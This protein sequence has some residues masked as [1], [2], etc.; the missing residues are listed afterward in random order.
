MGIEKWDLKFIELANYIATWSKDNS[1][2]V[3]S[4]IVDDS[5]RI[6]S[7]GYNGM[8]IG[9]DD[10]VKS[11]YEKPQKYFYFEHSERNAIYSCAYAGK[12][13]KNTTI[14]VQYYPCADCAR[15]IIQSGIKRVVCTKPDFNNEKWGES[16]RIA[17]ELFNECGIEVKYI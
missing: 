8:P 5:N 17:D 7:T 11:R 14:Y 3:G 15:A 12:S 2:K 4:V 6:V 13:T 9:F 16:W 1:T 10:S